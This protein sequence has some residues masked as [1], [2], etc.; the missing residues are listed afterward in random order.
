MMKLL[1]SI[2]QQTFILGTPTLTV[3]CAEMSFGD[4]IDISCVRE[5]FLFGDE[6][7]TLTVCVACINIF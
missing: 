6:T 3:G 1:M 2:L 7:Y 4:W 5:L